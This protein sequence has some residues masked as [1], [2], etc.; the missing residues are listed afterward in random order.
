[1]SDPKTLYDDMQD[2]AYRL[3]LDIGEAC[4]LAADRDMSVEFVLAMEEYLDAMESRAAALHRRLRDERSRFSQM[5]M[6][7]EAWEDGR[8]DGN[9]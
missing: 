3:S 5:A 4:H 2:M 1:M 6:T 9:A 8:A 7:I